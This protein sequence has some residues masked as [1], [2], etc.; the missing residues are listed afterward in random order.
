VA[1]L[2]VSAAIGTPVAFLG[3]ETRVITGTTTP[4]EFQAVAV[5]TDRIEG[6]WSADG[7]LS[8][9]AGYFSESA[10]A[11]VVLSWARGGSAVGCPVLAKGVWP[12]TGVQAAPLPSVSLSSTR[13]DS[14]RQTRSVVYS[15]GESVSLVVPSRADSRDGCGP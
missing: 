4:T 11:G 2:V 10:A 8:R 7:H 13:Y 5:A 1:I 12:R 6:E 15:G 9:V 3:P 14:W